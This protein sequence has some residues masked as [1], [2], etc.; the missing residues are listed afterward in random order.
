MKRI[1]ILFIVS[2][3]HS[4]ILGIEFHSR[5][6]LHI[7]AGFSR[8]CYSC[9]KEPCQGIGTKTT[10]DNKDASCQTYTMGKSLLDT[11]KK[12]LYSIQILE[13][14]NGTSVVYKGCDEEE[15]NGSG[16]ISGDTEEGG[17]AGKLTVC[18]CN[19][20]LCNSCISIHSFSVTVCFLSIIHKIF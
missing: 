14:T 6:I 18:L 4:G 20:D 15:M 1:T 13:L 7:F 17:L 9:T 16:C 12:D 3:L 8:E 5:K 10:C 2:L 11:R 19:E